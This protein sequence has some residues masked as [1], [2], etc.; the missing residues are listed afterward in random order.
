MLLVSTPWEIA[1]EFVAMYFLLLL[2]PESGPID[3][4]PIDAKPID[5]KPIDIDTLLW[6]SVIQRAKIVRYGQ[7]LVEELRGPGAL[8]AGL[9]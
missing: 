6:T 2:R 1:T 3:A 9:D 8:L 5:A 4:K 7:E